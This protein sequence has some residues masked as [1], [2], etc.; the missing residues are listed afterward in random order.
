MRFLLRFAIIHC[1]ACWLLAI[2]LL[3]SYSFSRS[4]DPQ[5]VA[6]L[7]V[8]GVCAP[9][10]WP[11]AMAVTVGFFMLGPIGGESAPD[12]SDV[13]FVN[14]SYLI[15]LTLV[16]TVHFLTCRFRNRASRRQV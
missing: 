7:V 8:A 2:V 9:I 13:A 10:V 6:L 3:T 16:W 5:I 12:L 14:C 15:S 4:S 1:L 11:L